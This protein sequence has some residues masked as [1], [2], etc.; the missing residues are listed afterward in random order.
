MRRDAHLRGDMG[1]IWGER[2]GRYREMRLVRRDAHLV[3]VRV[4]VRVRMRVRVRVRVRARARARARAGCV[5]GEEDAE[6][7]TDLSPSKGGE[8]TLVG[9][10]WSH[11]RGVLGLRGA[12]AA[13]L[14][15]CVR[16]CNPACQRLQPRASE[17][18]T[19]RVRGCN[20]VRQRLPATPCVRGCNP[21]G[22]SVAHRVAV[23]LLHAPRDGHEG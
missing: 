22:H 14:Q 21:V 3:R 4:R 20:L 8:R 7:N 13:R 1:Q 6:P 2:S 15:P 16:G 12:G 10:D 9:A 11:A 5:D 23:F 17:A 19:P 18:T